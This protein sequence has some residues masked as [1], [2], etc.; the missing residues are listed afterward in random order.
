MINKL[1]A[2]EL[3]EEQV[4]ILLKVVSDVQGRMNKLKEERE[5]L[6]QKCALLRTDIGAKASPGEDGEV[7][8]LWLQHS[9][10]FIDTLHQH[11]RR[12]LAVEEQLSSYIH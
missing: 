3:G 5:R 7:L 12:V 4:D 6:H 1:N 8:R 2:I 9:D 10:V 11:M